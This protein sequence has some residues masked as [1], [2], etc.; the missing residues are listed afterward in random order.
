MCALRSSFQSKMQ[1]SFLQD[2]GVSSKL[3][4]FL[5][6]IPRNDEESSGMETRMYAV[7][8]FDRKLQGSLYPDTKQTEQMYENYL[9][10]QTFVARIEKWIWENF[11]KQQSTIKVLMSRDYGR[12][13]TMFYFVR[14]GKNPEY[15]QR[16]EVCIREDAVRAFPVCTWQYD[17]SFAYALPLQLWSA[18]LQVSFLQD[19][20][21]SN[22][23]VRFLCTIPIGNHDYDGHQKRFQVQGFDR[24]NLE[25]LSELQMKT[26][27]GGPYSTFLEKIERWVHINFSGN[28]RSNIRMHKVWDKQHQATVFYFIDKAAL[29][30]NNNSVYY[31]AKTLQVSHLWDTVFAVPVLY[32]P[33]SSN[34]NNNVRCQLCGGRNKAFSE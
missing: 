32:R 17:D 2:K 20:A 27:V 22:S 24:K 11:A 10:F 19:K 25:T 23:L 30:S 33:P 31:H 16:L 5:C 8:G 18:S 7:Q 26:Y 1:V 15:A 14:P 13:S 21:V 29:G 6:Q 4:R 28:N 12:G 3:V 9:P 34:N